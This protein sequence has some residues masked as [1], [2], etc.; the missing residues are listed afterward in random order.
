MAGQFSH[1]SRQADITGH[2]CSH[3]WEP[4][5]P[6]I[7]RLGS[8]SLEFSRVSSSHY[9]R[10][11]LVRDH[12]DFFPSFSGT[13]LNHHASTQIW[14]WIC[15]FFPVKYQRRLFDFVPTVLSSAVALWTITT[16]S[17]YSFSSLF[18]P[19]SSASGLCLWNPIRYEVNSPPHLPLA[20][21]LLG[22]PSV[23]CL[24]SYLGSCAGGMAT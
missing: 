20:R 9:L 21:V 18:E 19:A 12:S 4:L 23:P 3:K 6:S 24:L 17:S 1:K 5:S 14:I 16:S 7:P 22:L 10:R 2:T 11:S 15:F 8:G 13:R